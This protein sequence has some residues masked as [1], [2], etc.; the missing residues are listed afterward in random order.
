MLLQCYEEHDEAFL[1][2]LVTGDKTWVFHYTPENKAESMTWR[3][4]HS[5][6]KKK[7]KTVQSPRKV[8]VTVFWDVHG[9]LFV[10]FKTPGSTIN[11]AAYQ[12]T[13]KILKDAIRRKRPGL[14]TKGLGVIL[15]D[16]ARPH[17]AAA[18]VNLLNSWGWEILP[19]PPYSPDLALGLPSIPKDEK[20]PQAL[21]LQ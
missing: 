6:V 1:S 19:H 15:H 8:M 9:V 20:A 21:P 3:H 5:P 11:A 12:E 18:T 14:L 17:S 10:D 4:P 13:L 16:N 2:R 7:F